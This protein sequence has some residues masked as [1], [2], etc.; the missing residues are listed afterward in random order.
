MHD[1]KV[2]R[3]VANKFVKKS[4]KTVNGKEACT[5]FHGNIIRI[6]RVFLLLV[7]KP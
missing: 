4:F 3:E 1:Q 2:D 6:Q 5:T 7:S